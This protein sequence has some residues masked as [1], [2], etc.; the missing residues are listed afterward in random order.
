MR[1]RALDELGLSFLV[2]YS[3][4]YQHHTEGE[5]DQTL[6]HELDVVAQ[7]WLVDS[8]RWGRGG[9]GLLFSD[10]REFLGTSTSEFSHSLGTSFLTNDTNVEGG[11]PQLRILW[12][13]QTLLE[14]RLTL[15][16]GQLQLGNLLDQNTYAS[17][18]RT[19]F[20]AKPLAGASKDFPDSGLGAGF[21]VRVT[22]GLSLFAGFQDTTANGQY[23]DFDSLVEGNFVYA[24]ELRF[25]S[26]F[27]ALGEGAYRFTGFYLPANPGTDRVWGLALSF[28]Q[29]V[30]EQLGLFV[31]WGYADAPEATAS[32]R[33]RLGAGVVWTRPF[34]SSEDWLGLGFIWVRPHDPS[35][36]DEY[37]L[38]TYWRIQLT[39]RVQFT[40]DLQLVFEPSLRPEA[41]FAAVGGLRIRFTF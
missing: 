24:A 13:E 32:I 38:E 27:D 34:G 8:E 36:R 5:R 33:S 20:F 37:A 9:I 30:H 7:W 23:P 40:P 1:N 19:S 28:D 16:A 26:P 25:D 11:E 2:D 22:P 17:D 14:E 29:A 15:V 18:D 12:W 31:R 6:N 35:L 10:L 39:E 3:L 4:M 21:A 41:D